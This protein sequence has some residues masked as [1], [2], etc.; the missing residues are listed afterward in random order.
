MS[1]Q[2]ILSIGSSTGSFVRGQY[3]TRLSRN[4]RLFSRFWT[5]RSWPNYLKCSSVKSVQQRT[6]N[7]VRRV[8]RLHGRALLRISLWIAKRLSR[9]QAGSL[10]SRPGLLLGAIIQLARLNT[11]ST[12]DGE[13]TKLQRMLITRRKELAWRE[14]WVPSSAWSH[15]VFLLQWTEDRW[16]SFRETK[17]KGGSHEQRGKHRS[18]SLVLFRCSSVQC[19]DR[20]SSRWP[21]DG[22]EREKATRRVKQFG[23]SSSILHL[24]ERIKKRIERRIQPEK[25]KG[26]LSEKRRKTKTS[27]RGQR[28]KH[29]GKEKDQ[30]DQ[31]KNEK[32]SSRTTIA[33]NTEIT[34]RRNKQLRR[35]MKNTRLSQRQT[36]AFTTTKTRNRRKIFFSKESKN[37]SLTAMSSLEWSKDQS[38]NWTGSTSREKI[39]PFEHSLSKERRKPDEQE[40]SDRTEKDEEQWRDQ[41]R[42]VTKETNE[43]EL[44]F[45]FV[46]KCLPR[47]RDS[48]DKGGRKAKWNNS[49]ER[50]A[51]KQ[52]K[53]CIHPN[54]LHSSPLTNEITKYQEQ[55][56]LRTKQTFLSFSLLTM[57]ND[58]E[59]PKERIH[60]APMI[61]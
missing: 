4:N 42:R 51:C 23:I 31:H 38:K 36:N 45:A 7:A 15:F 41:H 49:I 17:K 43:D 39:S 2:R 16:R 27:G 48:T 30:E 50:W 3:E 57:S 19:L 55:S 24:N 34:T 35:W 44:T 32:R 46:S 29:V 53:H 56:S 26:D 58:E 61:R 6:S 10:S 11:R 5:A 1:C 28:T 54:I 14:R 18:M 60:T 13:K 25:P 52:T 22:R 47:S 8:A 33:N 12:T 21:W 37:A 20:F 9:W 40:T 59:L